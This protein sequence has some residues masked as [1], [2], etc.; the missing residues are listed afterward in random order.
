MRIFLNPPTTYLMLRSAR[1]ARLEAR[2][3]PLWGF[4]AA[5]VNFLTSSFAGMTDGLVILRASLPAR[6]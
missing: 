2:T 4:W 5:S 1:W 6:L 3:A